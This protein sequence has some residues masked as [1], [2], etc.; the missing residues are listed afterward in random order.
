MKVLESGLLHSFGL[1]LFEDYMYWTDVN[2]GALYKAHKFH[3]KMPGNITA[4]IH[5]VTGAGPVKVLHNLVQTQGI[6]TMLI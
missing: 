3:A 1:A 5:Q 6:P 2:T 4:L